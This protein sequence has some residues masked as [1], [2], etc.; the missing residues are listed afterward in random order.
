VAVLGIVAH[1]GLEAVD[2][3]LRHGGALDRRGYRVGEPAGLLVAGAAM[4]D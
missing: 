2:R 3:V 4:G 1:R